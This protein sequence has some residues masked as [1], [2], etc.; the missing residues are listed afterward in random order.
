MN[1]I[2][3][4]PDAQG[5]VQ[6]YPVTLEEL[7]NR[8]FPIHLAKPVV[9]G[10]RPT[11]KYT[12][13]IQEERVLKDEVLY[14]SWVEVARSEDDYW[15]TFAAAFNHNAQG[16]DSPIQLSETIQVQNLMER[17]IAQ[18]LDEMARKYGYTNMTEL[19]SFVQS[20]NETFRR[21]AV[22]AIALR[23]KLWKNFYQLMENVHAKLSVYPSTLSE[24]LQVTTG[25]GE[26]N[27]D[28]AV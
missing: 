15:A 9:I 21:E 3:Y 13:F 10:P 17:R 6:E 19:V 27:L 20:K 26:L 2:Y 1:K 16:G 23:D 12:H 18:A 5:S 4:I 28:A 25:S 11:L 22:A 24:V 8:S 14:V 7:E